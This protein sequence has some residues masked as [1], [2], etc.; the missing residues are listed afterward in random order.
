MLKV[1]IFEQA[2]EEGGGMEV[3]YR[4]ADHPLPL[5]PPLPLSR[6]RWEI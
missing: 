3:W 4:T 2:S 6:L 1:K 5:P